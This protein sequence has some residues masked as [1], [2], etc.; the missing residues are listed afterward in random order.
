MFFG[1]DLGGCRGLYDVAGRSVMPPNRL[2]RREHAGRRWEMN[3]LWGRRRSCNR[4]ERHARGL[5]PSDV[6][7][8]NDDVMPHSESVLL[9]TSSP[10]TVKIVGDDIGESSPSSAPLPLITTT[11]TAAA[12]SAFGA[13]IVVAYPEEGG[14]IA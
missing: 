12:T 14:R 10:P 11:T 2:C 6:E 8:L 13:V 1:G 4:D 9:F 3:G 7:D 5:P